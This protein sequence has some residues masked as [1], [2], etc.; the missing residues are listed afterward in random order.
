MMVERPREFKLQPGK[1]RPPSIP[2]AITLVMA[3]AHIGGVPIPELVGDF[4][5]AGYRCSECTARRRLYD[6]GA[7]RVRPKKPNGM[8]PKGLAKRA[9]RAALRRSNL[10][11]TEGRTMPYAGHE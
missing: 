1:G 6:M 8:G 11:Y 9:R 10:G 4:A 7:I 5:A 2:Q 3:L